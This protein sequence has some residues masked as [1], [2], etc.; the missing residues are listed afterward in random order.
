MAFYDANSSGELSTKLGTD[1]RQASNLGGTV[2]SI[3]MVSISSIVLGAIF[4]SL[5]DS[6]M[7]LIFISFVPLLSFAMFTSEN[8]KHSKS[9]TH[10]LTESLVSDTLT[11]IK[12]VKALHLENSFI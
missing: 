4:A 5:Y 1:C 6:V 10:K 8:V 11:N 7:A 3:N 2:L 12:T 9:S